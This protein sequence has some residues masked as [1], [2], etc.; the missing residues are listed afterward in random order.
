MKDSCLPWIYQ[1]TVDRYLN[2][3]GK[4]VMYFQQKEKRGFLLPSRKVGKASIKDLNVF[5]ECGI[6]CSGFI[7]RV[8]SADKSVKSIIKNTKQSLLAELRYFLRPF[9][10]IAVVDIIDPVNSR[11]VKFL[12]LRAGDL[13]NVGK[14][15]V[16]LIVEIKSGNIKYVHASEYKGV[17]VEEVIKIRNTKEDLGS[18][19]W[20]SKYD[21]RQFMETFGSGTRRFIR[22]P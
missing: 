10:N 16:M 8:V 4:P 9:C 20:S 1:K 5:K 21:L 11:E 14:K 19:R 12:N 15:H 18:Q 2:L 22:W 7:C 6:D 3:N 17:V 13:I